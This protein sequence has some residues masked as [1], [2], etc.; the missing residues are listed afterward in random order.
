MITIITTL[1]AAKASKQ[2][3]KQPKNII[4]HRRLEAKASKQSNWPTT[5]YSSTTFTP[6]PIINSLLS[7]QHQ[8]TQ[9]SKTQQWLSIPFLS[10]RYSS[11]SSFSSSQSRFLSRLSFSFPSFCHYQTSLPP[12]SQWSLLYCNIADHRSLFDEL[13]TKG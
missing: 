12:L 6:P 4:A 7:N 2:L 13:Q 11:S 9:Q 8:S 3:T 10:T 5:R 1:Q